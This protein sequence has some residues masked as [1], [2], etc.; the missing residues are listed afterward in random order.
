[1]ICRKSIPL[2]S[3]VP[4]KLSFKAF[5]SLKFLIPP[6]EA[7]FLV[8]TSQ[9]LLQLCESK[10]IRDFNPLSMENDAI[11]LQSDFSTFSPS[12]TAFTL[13]LLPYLSRSYAIFSKLLLI[14]LMFMLVLL[15]LLLLLVVT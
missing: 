10:F 6:C 9:T 13:A 4:L 14:W 1:M 2:C 3:F 8:D 5:E 12:H 15:Q 7:L 11:V